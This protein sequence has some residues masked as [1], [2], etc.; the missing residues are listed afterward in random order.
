[1]LDCRGVDALRLRFPNRERDDL[2]LGQGVHALGHAADGRPCLVD[3]PDDALVQ[4]CIDRRGTWLQLRDRAPG[5]HVNGRPVRRMAMLRAGDSVHID[6]IELTLVGA[7]PLPM[8][9]TVPDLDASDSRIVL[10]G[11]GG[12]HH[13]RCFTL[14]RSR[15]IG[16]SPE[17]D[18]RINEPTFADRHARL[19]PHHDGVLLR[20][21][22]AD[23]GT[24]VN[25]HPV[26]DA[27]LKPG[28]Q[29]VFGS[30]HRFVLES[31]L[32]GPAPEIPAVPAAEI[33]A[34]SSD[35][36]PRSPVASSLRR[37]PWLLLAALLL[38]A[39]LTL[40]LVYGVR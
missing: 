2:V 13:G 20:D 30:Q 17:C 16:R 10:R 1:M 21:L 11:L 12:V 32:Q 24:M 26:R 29:L 15:E 3:H 18:I 7:D 8:P 9:S 27:L 36:P 5:L 37:L 19:E 31:P 35:A 4:F 28:D 40:L 22:S 25:G 34:G 23:S 39:A 14:D 33:E 6:G 38:A